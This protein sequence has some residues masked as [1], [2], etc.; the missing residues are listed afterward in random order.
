MLI[1]EVLVVK[2]KNCNCLK[3]FGGTTRKVKT[4][5]RLIEQAVILNT[6]IGRVFM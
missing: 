3:M 5:I 4:E 2:F 1:S 6:M